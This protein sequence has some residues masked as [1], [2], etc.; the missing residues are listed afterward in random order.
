[1]FKLHGSFVLLSRFRLE[2]SQIP[3]FSAWID[4]WEYRRYSRFWVSI[5]F[6]FLLCG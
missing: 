1:M 3:P 6:I 5:M 2:R 4:L